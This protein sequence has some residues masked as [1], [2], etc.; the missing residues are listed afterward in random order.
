MAKTQK[1]TKE[2]LRHLKEAELKKKLLDLKSNILDLR[3]KAQGSK[4][5]NVKQFSSLRK[6][7]ARVLTVMNVPKV[8]K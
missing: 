7:V 6:Q 1:E 8:N 3:F 5:K 4:S 2:N